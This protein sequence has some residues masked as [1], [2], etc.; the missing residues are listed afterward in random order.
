[1]SY[2]KIRVRPLTTALGAEIE[3]VDLSRP[4]NDETMAE[5]HRA[6]LE[7]LVI[8]FHDQHITPDQQKEF[9][10][11]FGPLNIHPFVEPMPGHPE[12]LEVLKDVDDAVN[13]GGL[14]HIDLTFLEEPPLGSV[15]YARE[16]P[17]SGGDTLWSNMYLAHDA[18]SD[19]MKQMLDGLVAIHSA[20]R[21]YGPE[22]ETDAR[23]TGT[24]M[25]LDQTEDAREAV[26]H[27]LVR[28]H[29]ETGR[30]GLFLGGGKYL[31]RF[32]DMSEE[33]SRPVIQFLNRHATRPEFT[34]RFRWRE[35]A[36]A[37]W[38]NRCTQHFA[39][40]D[41]SGQRRVMHRTTINGD[42]PV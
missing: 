5:I 26:E 25:Q 1:M 8:F 18:L 2:R 33:E 39:L 41:Y 16:T 9:S 27:P 3:G 38:D 11:Y 28:T 20:L 22:D 7:N 15:L 42:R 19:G 6:F 12:I 40:N 36:V 29:P 30:K 37:F 35:N 23:A 4:Q 34:C 24:S 17:D 21:V 10:R 32:K 14:W 13:F 31:R